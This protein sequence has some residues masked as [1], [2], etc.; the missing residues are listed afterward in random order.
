[1]LEV[2]AVSNTDVYQ[3]KRAVGDGGGRLKVKRAGWWRRC[4]CINTSEQSMTEVQ[5]AGW[6]WRCRCINTSEHFLKYKEQDGG[7]IQASSR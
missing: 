7:A 6:W 2:F 5:R 3:Y 4:R 1:V